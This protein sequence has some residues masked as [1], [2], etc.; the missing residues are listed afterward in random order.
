MVGFSISNDAASGGSQLTFTINGMTIPVKATETYEANFAP[1]KSVTITTTVPYRATVSMPFSTTVDTIAPNNV[2][3]LATSNV[4]TNGLTLTWNASSSTDTAGYDIYQ[5]STLLTSVTDTTYNITGLTPSTSYTFTVKAKDGSGNIASGVS[6]T[7]STIADTVAPNNVTNLTTSN[8]SSTTLTLTWSASSSTDT[9]GYEVYNDS[10][11]LT[12]VTGT[13]YNVSGLTASTN[14]TFTV[15]AKDGANNVASGVSVS[16]TTSAVADTTAPNNVTNLTTSNLSTTSV[17][18]NWTASTSTDTVGYDI[19]NGATL[20]TSTANT[21]YTVTS[22]TEKTQYTFTIKAKDASNNVASGTSVTVTTVDATAPNNVTNLTTASVTQT[23]LTL[24]WTASTSSDIASYDV[25]QESTLLGNVTGTTYNV[26][27]LTAST[28]YTFTVK[29]KDATG[30]VSTGS[31]VTVT[32]SAPADTTAPTVTISPAAGTYS[33]TQSVTLTANETAT[34]YYTTDN[35]TPTY[36]VS[37]TTQVY[38]TAISVSATTV[39]KYFG[40]DTAGNSST[41]QTAT[42]TINSLTVSDSFNRVDSSTSLG[43]SDTGQTWTALTGTW[44]ISSNQAYLAAGTGGIAVID[45]GKSDATIQVKNAVITA[46]NMR[47]VFRLTD[48]NNYYIVQTDTGNVYK[49][50]KNVA[51]TFTSLGTSTGIT[52]ANGD[53]LKVVTNGSSITVYVNGSQI[54]TATDTFNQTATKHGIAHNALNPIS[55]WD[56]F[57]VA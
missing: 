37:G 20:V 51:G 30:N 34:I 41:I 33:S 22:L 55:R 50:Y 39:I 19:Y 24:N 32:T 7:I 1:Y 13:T 3:G 17:T 53:V 21:S 29:S 57:S 48:S 14:Y 15:K 45:S 10:T 11:L 54:I 9:T 6:V 2:T 52:P 28:Q 38:S 40:R 26:S 4:S 31:S 36:P 16:V 42:Y 43:V 44:G 5:G 27:G 47:F 8:V 35:T 12:T 56:D 18:L 46:T 23:S 25:Y 49:L